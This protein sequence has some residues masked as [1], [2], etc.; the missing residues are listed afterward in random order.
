[1][2]RSPWWRIGWRNLGRNR[3]RTL[4]TTGGLALGFCAVVVMGGLNRGLIAEMIGNGTGM[5]DG[6]LQV[7]SSGYLPERSLYE[8]IGGRDG[9]DVERLVEAVTADPVVSA[10]TPRVF[11]GGL[12]S[13]GEATVAAALIGIDPG[14]EPNV[15]TILSTLDEGRLPRPGANELVV[16]R[17]MAR[18]LFLSSG[19][20][21]VLVAPAADG[22]M[23]ND[24]FTVA[25]IFDTG[26]AELDRG[27][28]LVPIAAL[29]RLIALP[30]SRIH[31]I[32]ARVEDPWRAPD[33]AA[34]L[35]EPIAS[36]EAEAKVSPWTT[37]RPEMV[38]YA[39][40]AEGVEWMLLVIV[41]AIA[42][43]GVANTMLMATFERRHEFALLLALGTTPG[44]IVRSVLAEAAVLSTVSLVV[45][46]V[47]TAPILVWW[48]LAPPDMSWLY[49]GTTLAG[50]LMR[51]ILRV[52]YPWLMIVEAAVALFLVA[53]LAALY[54]AWRSA[55]VPPADTLTGR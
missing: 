15:S 45:G 6:Q 14:R 39:T 4:F 54:P 8:T 55:R 41:F 27:L 52:E 38:S 48:K 25:G 33:A 24:L 46:A 2:F 12:V 5:L 26:L 29:Q 18:Q 17:E 53:V 36:A 13:S 28:A 51:P 40:M 19:D 37:F 34:R 7:H 10:S 42:I 32:A 9:T 11:A 21:T 1:M 47:I 20:E 23:G 49:G 31:E 35:A 16:G 3:R 44:V 22:S 43:F 50:G 30:E